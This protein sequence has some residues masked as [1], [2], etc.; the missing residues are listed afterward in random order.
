MWDPAAL[1][2]ST[3]WLKKRVCPVNKWAW[4]VNF[5]SLRLPADTHIKSVSCLLSRPFWPR[6]TLGFVAGVQLGYSTVSEA[7]CETT[8]WAARHNT[9]ALTGGTAGMLLRMFVRGDGE[10]KT[11][12]YRE[13]EEKEEEDH[14][15]DSQSKVTTTKGCRQTWQPKKDSR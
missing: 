11:G 1:A 4:P 13:E 12:A 6:V 14:P 5:G 3:R 10:K 2:L 8:M 7:L 9:A 15:N